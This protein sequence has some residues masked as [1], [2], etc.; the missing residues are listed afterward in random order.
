MSVGRRAA[1]RRLCR[2][3]VVLC[4]V[5]ASAPP[6]GGGVSGVGAGCLVRRGDVGR[7]GLVGKVETWMV[8]GVRL[9]RTE[10]GGTSNNGSFNSP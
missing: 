10:M 2:R 3:G 1:D 4:L 9:D 5:F 6:R 7:F 8:G